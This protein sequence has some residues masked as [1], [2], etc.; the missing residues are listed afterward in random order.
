[1]HKFKKL[2]KIGWVRYDIKFTNAV[3][4]EELAFNEEIN[5]NFYKWRKNFKK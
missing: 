4:S 5:F 1:M 3:D 2:K